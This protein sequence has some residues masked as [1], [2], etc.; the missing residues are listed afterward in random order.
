MKDGGRL[1]VADYS[2]NEESNKA[3]K[4]YQ[5]QKDLDTRGDRRVTVDSCVMNRFVVYSDLTTLDLSGQPLDF[6]LVQLVDL[7]P[8][9][10]T[11]PS[12]ESQLLL[13]VF[14]IERHLG[15]AT[16][17]QGDCRTER[18]LRSCGQRKSEWI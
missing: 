5:S 3:V 16:E 6:V 4:R 12:P 8:Q 10:R 14:D 9:T 1:N 7:F 15:R 13:V 11:F 2:V 17:E 18:D